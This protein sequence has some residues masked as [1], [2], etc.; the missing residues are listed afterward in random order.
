MAR[1]PFAQWDE[2]SG[3]V[4]A[5][6]GGPFKIIH[7]TTEGTSYEGARSA[8][9]AKRVDPHFTVA[10]NQIYQHIDTNRAARALKFS[11]VVQK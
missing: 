9:V 1:C 5:F 4:G 10:G 2:I 3:D 6:A 8:Y 7:H 11:P